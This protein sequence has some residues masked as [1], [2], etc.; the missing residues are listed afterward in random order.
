M[1]KDATR[2]PQKRDEQSRDFQSAWLRAQ[3]RQHE[4]MANAASHAGPGQGARALR[5][6]LGRVRSVEVNHRCIGDSSQPAALAS[7][8]KEK[9]IPASGGIHARTRHPA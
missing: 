8:E 6:Q 1:A 9:S 3:R 2:S 7:T 5:R 4:E